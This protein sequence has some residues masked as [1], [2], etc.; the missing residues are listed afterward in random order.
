M[1]RRATAVAC[2]QGMTA[3]PP[4]GPYSPTVR[5]TPSSSACTST[6][7]EPS[8]FGPA[9]SPL[10]VTHCLRPA[11]PSA[12][13]GDATTNPRGCAHPATRAGWPMTGP[14]APHRHTDLVAAALGTPSARQLRAPSGDSRRR[15]RGDSDGRRPTP[16]PGESR[17]FSNRRL[18]R[19]SSAARKTKVASVFRPNASEH[20]H[21]CHRR[22]SA[23]GRCGLSLWLP[24]AGSPE[25]LAIVYN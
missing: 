24:A 8:S 17:I 7:G 25:S 15:A 22:T 1:M 14:G 13:S 16:P 5:C 11:C 9:T 6:R 3:S 21:L 23:L 2:G 10:R 19:P 20:A 4:G 18:A 12:H